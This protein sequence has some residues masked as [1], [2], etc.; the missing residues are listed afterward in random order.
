MNRGITSRNTYFGANPRSDVDAVG[1]SIGFEPGFLFEL[2]GS[3]GKSETARA[4][5]RRRV[6]SQQL[7]RERR[8]IL[9]YARGTVAPSGGRFTLARSVEPPDAMAPQ[10]DRASLK[11]F[12]HVDDPETQRSA[13][14]RYCDGRDDR[15]RSCHQA[16]G[17][18]DA[19]RSAHAVI[20][21]RHGSS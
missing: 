8:E 6:A 7:L 21:G 19:A 11:S 20:P 4:L 16:R 12:S 3:W 14:R 1:A 15:L 17:C 5:E 13:H 10:I 2:G 9:R 18:H